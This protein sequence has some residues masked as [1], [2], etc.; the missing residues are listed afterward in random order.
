MKRPM[1]LEL[2][3]AIDRPDTVSATEIGWRWRVRATNG[4]ILADS[5]EAYVRL[6]DCA[7]GAGMVTG[8]DLAGIVHAGDDYLRQ[9][10][11]P[12]RVSQPWTTWRVTVEA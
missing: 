7:R 8:L 1:K 9:Q 10:A 2:Y 11:T 6:R 12:W 5:G 4:R 3:R